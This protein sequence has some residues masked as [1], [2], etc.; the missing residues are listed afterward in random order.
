M[1]DANTKGKDWSDNEV[2]LIVAQYFVMLRAELRQ[3]HFN[4]AEINRGIQ[5]QIGRSKGSVEFKNQNISAVLRLLGMPWIRGYK[6][7]INFQ[8]ALID[9]IERFLDA[10]ERPLDIPETVV[11]LAESAG[12]YF[13]RPP[14]LVSAQD[15]LNDKIVRLVR[16]FDPAAQD[17]QNRTLGHSGEERVF[18][19]ERHRLVEIGQTGLAKKVR[20]VSQEDGDGAGYDILSFDAEGRERLLE[21]KTTRGFQKTPFFLS[22][23]EYSLSEERPD[24]FRI[25]RLYDFA[26]APRAFELVPPLGDV[27]RLRT[28][29][30]RASFA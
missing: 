5:T 4:K 21:V 24:A 15:V 7:L 16:K 18:R 25:V 19:F 8:H 27:V 13:E 1:Q 17:E 3:Q 12:L 14:D 20:W 26:R 28:E 9:G 29:I 30:Y 2:D 11:H 6:P 22:R 23:N 10:T